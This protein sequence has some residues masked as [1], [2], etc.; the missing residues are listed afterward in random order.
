MIN[1]KTRI[2][3]LGQILYIYD[4]YDIA[5]YFCG[6][7]PGGIVYFI[8]ENIYITILLSINSMLITWIIKCQLSLQKSLNDI[9]FFTSS[10][11]AIEGKLIVKNVYPILDEDTNQL[12]LDYHI[13]NCSSGIIKYI[14]IP[15]KSQFLVNCETTKAFEAAIGVIPPYSN[16]ILST[17]PISIK[18]ND[19]KDLN[20]NITSTTVLS[21]WSYVNENEKYLLSYDYNI[22]LLLNKDVRKV[23]K[24]NGE[25]FELSTYPLRKNR[26]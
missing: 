22:Q 8:M 5:Q 17:P 14:T 26:N 16:F 4:L 13:H 19:N 18:V 11:K 6:C 23:L 9:L 10:Q 20:I 25:N 3:R 12:Y 2:K 21:Y 1:I 7:I 15:E 24:V